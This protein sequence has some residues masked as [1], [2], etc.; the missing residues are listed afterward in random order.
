MKKTRLFI[1]DTI[2]LRCKGFN[3]SPLKSKND[4]KKTKQ[5][6]QI[7]ITGLIIACEPR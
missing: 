6:K 1:L 5:K 2:S 7:H 4:S 3:K